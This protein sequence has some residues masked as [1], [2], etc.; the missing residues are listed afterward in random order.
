MSRRIFDFVSSS[1]FVAA[2]I[3]TSA[4]VTRAEDTTNAP[5][6]EADL[7]WKEVEKATRPPMPPAEWQTQRPTQ[8]QVE[9][10]R[11]Q[12]GRLAGEAADKAGEFAKKYPD[13]PKAAFA[14]KQRDDLVRIA[15]R[16]GNTNKIAEA[17]KLDAERAKDTSVPED[18]RVMLRMRAVMNSVSAGGRPDY[19][20]AAREIIKEFPGRG[21]GYRLLLIAAQNSDGE[22]SRALVEEIKS[23]NAPQ[24]MKEAAEGLARKLDAL[25][26]P[27]D[28]AFTAVDGREVDLSKMKGK[29]VLVD[30]W[31]TW[32]G[33]C[34]AEMPNVKKAYEKFHSKGFEIVG[35][36]FDQSK[37][38][39]EQFVAKNEMSWPQYFDGAVWENKFGRR[40]GISGIPTV[41]LVD[42]KGLLRELDG[43][44]ELEEKVS[45][46]LAE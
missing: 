5:P 37:E 2:V 19:E 24:D 8:E 46:L 23:S 9:Q 38:T 10:F 20:K 41:W 7:A 3:I 29:V 39:L 36:S 42:K 31:A 40:Y 45:R 4:P 16:L 43:R 33:P 14:A 34:V 28:I 1:L 26:K 13:H 11:A 17:E 27:L 22:K 18:E 21:E 12:Q 35:I 6:S 44:G 15:V 25:G 30:F 32:C